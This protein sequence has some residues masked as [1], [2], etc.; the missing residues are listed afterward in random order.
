MNDRKKY[1]TFPVQG[2]DGA[3][4]QVTIGSI[5][6]EPEGRYGY[7]KD[8]LEVWLEFS[9]CVGST[10][11]TFTELPIKE[12]TGDEFLLAIMNGAQETVNRLVVEHEESDKARAA[13]EK[14]KAELDAYAERV[15]GLL[16]VKGDQT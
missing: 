15:S 6:A 1:N 5:K 2:E 13:A 12:Y 9:P 14:H 3:T 11:G 4:Y 16:K 10:L 7:E 8:R